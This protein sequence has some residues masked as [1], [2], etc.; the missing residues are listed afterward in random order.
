LFKSGN[1]PRN[2]WKHQK[3]A[4]EFLI[5][6]LNAKPQRGTCLV[7]MP[8]GTGKTGVIAWLSMKSAEGKTLVLTPWTNLRDQMVAALK[9][10]FWK[11]SGIPQPQLSVRPL[12]PSSARSVLT[13]PDVKVIVSSL[14]ALT[15]LRRDDETSYKALKKLIDLVIVDEGHYEPAVEWGK[16]VKG[17]KKPT[18]LMTATPYRNDLKLFHISDHKE[19][20]WQF[21]HYQA[22]NDGIIRQLEFQSLGSSTDP[23]KLVRAFTAYWKKATQNNG[24]VS[25]APRAIICCADSQQIESVVTKLQAHGISSLGVHDR[26]HNAPDKGLYRDVP[27]VKTDADVW[28]HQYKLVEGLDDHRFCCVALFCTIQNDRK[29]VQQ[30]GRA[31]RKNGSDRSGK[32]AVL[33]APDEF[34]V[35]SSWQAY[36][37]FEKNAE[38]VTMGHY[39]AVVDQLLASQPEAEYF[40][41]RFRRRLNTGD[42]GKDPKITISPSV[43]VRKVNNNFSLNEYID[44][45]TDTLLMD[46][47]IILGP[48]EF[49]PCVKVKD[50]ALWVYASVRN[51][52]LLERDA[53]YEI[54]LEAHCAV[55]SDG[56]LLISDTAGSYPIELLDDRTTGTDPL[57]L[58]SLL[59]STF[60]LTNLSVSSAIPFDNVVRAAEIRGSDIAKIPASLTDR[61]QICRSARGAS[62]AHGRR[63]V[64]IKRGRVRQELS[65]NQLRSHSLSTFVAWCQNV[66][67]ALLA[68]STSNSVF[69]RYMQTCLPPSNLVAKNICVDLVRIGT[70]LFNRKGEPVRT[71]RS[72]SSL[73]PIEGSST[74]YQFTL[75]FEVLVD[76][77]ASIFEKLTAEYQPHKKRFWFKAGNDDQ[78]R[79]ATNDPR[80]PDGRSLQDYLNLNQDLVLIGLAGGEV[81]YQGRDFYAIDYRTAERSL[82]DRIVTLS[83]AAK[84]ATEKGTKDE[85]DAAKGLNGN[86]KQS[87]FATGSLFKAIV[88]EKDVIPFDADLLICDDLN[89]ECGDFVAADTSRCKLALLHAKIGDG[90]KI[91]ASSFHE[92]VAQAIK[93]L[94]YLSQNAE[95]PEGAPSW[96]SGTFWNQTAVERVVKAPTGVTLGVDLWKRL[97]ADI[98]QSA[99]GELHVVLVTAGCCDRGSLQDAIDDRSKRTPETAQLFHLLEG[100][101]GYSRQLGV[102]LTV[103]DIPFDDRLVVAAKAAAKKRKAAKKAASGRTASKSAPA[104]K[105][106]SGKSKGP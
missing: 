80:F 19:S 92:V 86:A 60:K 56:Y 30:I 73:E 52:R 31:L 40:D 64:G 72:A 57:E 48:D 2:L 70:G 7:R 105:K 14:A 84:C 44:D 71:K 26:F 13:D 39:R 63:Y 95:T 10:G 91:S 36:L 45:C 93:N 38:L 11:S 103:V 41:G 106:T 17:L 18:I 27:D 65:A 25:A 101:N 102:R 94:A 33:L 49:G 77:H 8:T 98:I 21:R 55:L 68:G 74:L 1:Y 97:N 83:G 47:A 61:V 79:V 89:S 12:L 35:E 81:V 53:L 88:S 3:D 90:A 59:D 6:H 76:P 51:S 28:V 37:D 24:L 67:R 22:E 96:K 16:S 29:L 69:G 34:G 99:D 58:S 87:T 82:L 4:L 62:T 9:V 104:A 46:D 85:L 20:V 54:R 23:D 15:D 100:L 43:L 78:I 42:L 50:H 32:G 5:G 75:E 66:A